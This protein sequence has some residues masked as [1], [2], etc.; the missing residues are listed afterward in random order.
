MLRLLLACLLPSLLFAQWQPTIIW[1]RPGTLADAW[2]GLQVFALGDQNADGFAD[3]G[4]SG[5]GNTSRVEL[6]HGGNPPAPTPYMSFRWDSTGYRFYYGGSFGDVNGDGYTDWYVATETPFRTVRWEIYFG[7]PAADTLPD[8]ILRTPRNPPAHEVRLRPLGDINGDGCDDIYSEDYMTD[9]AQVYFGGNP[10]DTLVDWTWLGHGSEPEAAMRGHGDLNGDGY[11]DWLSETW[12]PGIVY[13]WVFHGGVVPDTNVTYTI[14]GDNSGEDY[15]DAVAIV[16]DLNGDGRDKLLATASQGLALGWG[17]ERVHDDPDYFFADPCAGGGGS[18][19]RSIGDFNHDGYNDF[20]KI[21]ETCS[22]W[23]WN[24]LCALSARAPAA[25]ASPRRHS[26]WRWSAVKRAG[27]FRCGGRGR[28]ER[29]W[30][31]RPAAGLAAGQ[32]HARAGDH[33]CR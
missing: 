26:G 11:S 31:R 3:F 30:D 15:L 4:V 12:T 20:V 14:Y 25:A 19:V 21:S 23:Y 22:G 5:Y 8:V 28:C 6:F 2:Y 13:L 10:M 29:R 18:Q 32:R 27:V 7:G 24:G 9:V 17:A 1:E 16:N 33:H